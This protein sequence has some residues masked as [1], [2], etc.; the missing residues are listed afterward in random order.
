VTSALEAVATGPVEVAEIAS[1]EAFRDRHREATRDAT[2]PF[3]EAVLGA[4]AAERPGHAFASGYV[5][6]VRALAGGAP[7]AIQVLSVTERGGGHPRAIEAVATRD[8]GGFVL[9]GEK[10]WAT[11]APIADAILVV[12]N[13]GAAEG[14]RR[15][16]GVLRLDPRADG[17]T[18]T[19]MPAP[20]FAPEIPHAELRLDGARVAADALLPGDGWARW[21][22]PFRTVEDVHVLAALFAFM[23]RVARRDGLG[24]DLV[25]SLAGLVASLAAVAREPADAP[26]THVALG[27]AI[28]LGRRVIADFDAAAPALEPLT[29]ERWARDRALFAI[30]ERVREERLARAF[31]AIGA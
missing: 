20:P 4:L 30:A 29:G 19:P 16:L 28:A 24:R 13:V 11:L 26:A 12:A 27:G 9:T 21:V 3:D 15:A 10:R 25:A 18:I 2:S 1:I 31:E 17:V 5:A 6:A 22:K 23:A 8:A 14:S 7:G